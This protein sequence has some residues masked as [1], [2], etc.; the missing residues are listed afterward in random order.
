MPGR[1]GETRLT[2]T[3][4]CVSTFVIG[5][6]TEVVLPF[7]LSIGAGLRLLMAAGASLVA[8]D[9]LSREYGPG[10]SRAPAFALGILVLAVLGFVLGG[11]L[12]IGV[13]RRVYSRLIGWNRA[14]LPGRTHDSGSH[15]PDA[16]KRDD[17][18]AFAR[19]LR[20]VKSYLLCRVED[21][22]QLPHDLRL[23]DSGNH[24]VCGRRDRLLHG[25][26]PGP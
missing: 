22:H 16:V 24:I 10:L 4:H 13:P 19:M 9:E 14:A 20:S 8:R 7:L 12:W 23:C 6:I 26:L 2:R 17:E 5:G 11:R 15:A 18:N 25:S 3:F 1:A 21:P